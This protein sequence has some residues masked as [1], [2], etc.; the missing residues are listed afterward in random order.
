MDKERP[1]PPCKLTCSVPFFPR[2][3]HRVLV[4]TLVHPSWKLRKSTQQTMKKLL[5]G[6]GSKQM[7]Q[8]LLEEFRVVLAS[9]KV[10]SLTPISDFF[11]SSLRSY[12]HLKSQIFKFL[13]T[14]HFTVSKSR[15]CSI[16]SLKF[17]QIS[18][19][20]ASMWT[21][22]ISSLRLK[23][24]RQSILEPLFSAPSLHTAGFVALYGLIAQ[25]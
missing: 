24:W 7:A 16:L 4:T 18:V 2:P 17:G 25:I 9:Q 12:F 14:L 13:E 21:K 8:V 11:F 23:I 1:I 22:K 3:F 5:A 15:K 6:P 19:P 10:S 20:R